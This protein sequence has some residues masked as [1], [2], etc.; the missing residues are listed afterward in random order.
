MAK[1]ESEVHP[2]EELIK[3]IHEQLKE[4]LDE[5]KQAIY[6]YLDDHHM[7]YNLNIDH[8]GN[9]VFEF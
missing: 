7:T 8:F 6:V 3:G 4:I 5:S 2:H 1:K 9:Y